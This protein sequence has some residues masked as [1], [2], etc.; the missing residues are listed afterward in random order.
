LT[1]ASLWKRR[2]VFSFSFVGKPPEH[3]QAPGHSGVFIDYPIIGIFDLTKSLSL[4]TEGGF[5]FFI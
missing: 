2:E 5:F 3:G 1:K 4:E